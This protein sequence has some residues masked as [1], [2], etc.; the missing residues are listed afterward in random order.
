M[1]RKLSKESNV[2]ALRR[3]DDRYVRHT[4]SAKILDVS[5]RT[6]REWTSLKKL[7]HVKMGRAVRYSVEDLVAFAEANRVEAI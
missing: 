7:P 4:V 6:I 5:P 2:E 1:N 3:L